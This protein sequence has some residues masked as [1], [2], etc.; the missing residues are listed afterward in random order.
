MITLIATLAIA[1]FAFSVKVKDPMHSSEARGGIKG[2]VYNTCRG[3]NYAKTNT[4]PCQ[5]R[6]IR[7]LTIRRLMQVCT[8]AWALLDQTERNAWNTYANDHPIT[9][10]MGQ[11]VRLSGFNLY[12]GLNCR[13]LDLALPVSDT[14]PITAAPDGL[15][16][17]AAANG[18]RQSVVSWTPTVDPALL[19]T[20]YTYGPHSAGRMPK[21]ERAR[22]KAADDADSGTYTVTGLTPGHWTIFGFAVNGTN[23]L[24]STMIYDSCDITAV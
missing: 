13:L 15:A 14:P 24:I 17:F 22:F 7:Q 18:I 4:A 19:A 16:A 20:I 3:I 5:P 8:R 10:G 9:N 2:R 6:T 21:F 1:A 12:C 11:T 23:G